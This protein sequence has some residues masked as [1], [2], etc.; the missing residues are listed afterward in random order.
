M[1]ADLGDCFDETCRQIELAALPVA[2]QVLRALFDRAVALD[3]AWACDANE[4]CE[5]E[6][7]VFRLRDQIFEHLD[8]ALDGV[9]AGRLVVG[10]TP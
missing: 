7:L 9:L 10:M 2:W 6:S 5:L 4:R 3:D 1:L 8:E